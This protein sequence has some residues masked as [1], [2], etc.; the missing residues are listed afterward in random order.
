MVTG[1]DSFELHKRG[2][3]AWNDWA[4]EKLAEKD[5]LIQKGMWL[6]TEHSNRRLAGK[7]PETEGWLRTAKAEFASRD[8]AQANFSGFV[9][10]GEVSLDHTSFI[11]ADFSNAIFHELASF[12]NSTFAGGGGAALFDGV[13]FTKRV[14][15]EHINCGSFSAKGAQFAEAT[16]QASNL[17]AFHFSEVIFSDSALF[18]SISA[19]TASFFRVEFEGDVFFDQATFSAKTEFIESRFGGRISFESSSFNSSAHFDEIQ[20]CERANFFASRFEA[21]VNFGAPEFMAEAADLVVFFFGT[22]QTLFSAVLI[23]LLL[24]AIRNHFRIK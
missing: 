4:K 20:F 14:E 5:Q 21:Y 9:F 22:L 6:A 23:F 10:P 12:N 18:K 8:L 2:R 13:S 7:N 11:D 16:W 17:G 24:L 3:E 19:T 15:F 1:H